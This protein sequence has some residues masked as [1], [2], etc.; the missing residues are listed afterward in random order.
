M[1]TQSRAPAKAIRPKTKSVPR[2]ART[3]AAENSRTGPVAEA[4]PEPSA[5]DRAVLWHVVLIAFLA[6]AVFAGTLRAGFVWDDSA[7]IVKNEALKNLHSIPRFFTS[8]VWD[9]LYSHAVANYYR[10]IMYVMYALVY[11]LAGL[12]AGAFHLLNV[13]FHVLDAVLVYLLTLRLFRTSRMALIA[14]LIFA[15]HP[16]HTEAVAWIAALPEL[17][18]TCFYL[19]AFCFYLKAEETPGRALWW[20][21]AS[22]LAFSVSLLSKEMAYTLPLVL[23]AYGCLHLKKRFVDAMRPLAWYLIPA[24]VC[25]AARFHALRGLAPL[26]QFPEIT[27]YQF[28]LSVIA[29]VGQYWW[30]LAAPIRLNAFY[31]FEPSRSVFDPRVSL[32]F[33]AEA[34]LGWAMWKLW[35]S[36]NRQWFSIAWVFLTLLPALY[37]HGVGLNVFTERYLYL[38]SLGF[39]WLIAC[40]LLKLRKRRLATGLLVALIALFVVR[41]AVRAQVWNNEFD[42]DA[43]AVQESPTAFEMHNQ[44][45]VALAGKKRFAEARAELL[46][47]VR[48]Q[49]DYADGHQNLAEVDVDLGALDEAIAEYRLALPLKPDDAVLRNDFG[50]ALYLKGDMDSAISQFK[51]AVRLK[52]D[53]FEP[54]KNLGEIYYQRRAVDEALWCYRKCAALRPGCKVNVNLASLYVQRGLLDDA[55]RE[56]QEAAR[57]EPGCAEAYYDLGAIYSQKGQWDRAI[58]EFRRALSLHPGDTQARANLELALKRK[59]R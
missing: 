16:V 56:F 24:G 5:A 18:F 4:L 28:W 3:K 27:V 30:K 36:G 23:M 10:P 7:Q 45:G 43:N 19:L 9:L 59:V 39:C 17:I 12:Q 33:A 34:A 25:L 6:F 1:K 8:G 13:I 53:R 46:I 20:R 58:E 35:R 57:I 50:Y 21:I 51:E 55:V 22:V 32:A 40:L 49:P 54:Y 26:Y 38:P 42:L 2:G 41:T 48:L 37:I 31:V 52:P 29:L 44:L 14:G 15:V 47:S 11:H